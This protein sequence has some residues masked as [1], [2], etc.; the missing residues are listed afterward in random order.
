MPVEQAII[1]DRVY[2]WLLTEGGQLGVG[3]VDAAGDW[4]NLI[5]DDPWLWVECNPLEA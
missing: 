1:G 2:T 3:W 5:V 4:W